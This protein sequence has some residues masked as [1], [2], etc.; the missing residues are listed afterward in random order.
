[1]A[2]S[3]LVG[4]CATGRRETQQWLPTPAFCVHD[5]S[6]RKEAWVSIELCRRVGFL[7]VGTAPGDFR[8]RTPGSV[9]VRIMFRTRSV[10]SEKTVCGCNRPVLRRHFDIGSGAK[11]PSHSEGRQT[12]VSP[13]PLNRCTIP[14]MPLPIQ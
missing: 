8:R 12:F 3:P 7:I 9:D 1:L 10:E 11:A 6:S 14:E 13:G 2:G 4:L 5:D